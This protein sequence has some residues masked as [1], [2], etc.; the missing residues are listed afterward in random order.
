VSHESVIRQV[1]TTTAHLLVAADAVVR[2]FV[3]TTAR[4]N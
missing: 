4:P 1:D 2:E 3:P